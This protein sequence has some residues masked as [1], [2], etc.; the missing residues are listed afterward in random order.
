MFTHKKDDT[1]ARRRKV[2]QPKLCMLWEPRLTL[3][4]GASKAIAMEVLAILAAVVT[5]GPAAPVQLRNCDERQP[6]QPAQPQHNSQESDT[7]G[8]KYMQDCD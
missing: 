7:F 2:E 5:S 3:G 1:L 4:L 6:H 8:V